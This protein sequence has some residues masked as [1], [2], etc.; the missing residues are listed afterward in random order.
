MWAGSWEPRGPIWNLMGSPWLSN[1]G[2]EIP[3]GIHVGWELGA[4][5]SH[6]EPYGSSLALRLGF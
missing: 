3:S 2:L 5:R 6:V 4:M 1:L